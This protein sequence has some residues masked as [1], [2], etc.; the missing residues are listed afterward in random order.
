MTTKPTVM[1]YI[2]IGNKAICSFVLIFT[3]ILIFSCKPSDKENKH[4]EKIPGTD[5]SFHTLKKTVPEKSF[6]IDADYHNWGGSMIKSE[7][8]KYHLFYSRWPKA[9]GHIAWV[10][11]SEIAHAVADDPL[12]PYNFKDIALPHR[13]KEYWDG[14]MTHNPTIHKLGD[15]YYLYYIGTYGDGKLHYTA[16]NEKGE[17]I[18]KINYS[19]RNNQRIGVAIADHPEG[20]WKRFDEPLIDVSDDSTASDNLI[21]V[22]PSVARRPDGKYLLVYKAATKDYTKES[23]AGPVIHRVAISDSPDGPFIK[24]PGI[25]FDAGD[26]FFPAEDPYIWYQNDRFFAIVKDMHGAFTD[27]GRALVLFESKEGLNWTL[28]DKPL[29]SKLQ[30]E[31]AD[32]SIKKF[33]RLERPQLY[34]ENGKPAILFVA[35][36]DGKQ[37]YN[38]HIPLETDYSN[39]N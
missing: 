22:N 18:K 13:G 23:L 19:H 38:I 5:F 10:V 3:V 24:Q 33:Q 15:K 2:F 9:S 39:I 8:G 25:I 4:Q 26:S 35:V 16:K 36:R 32:G 34:F 30:I 1:N 28:A 27:K 21:V 17:T 6:L 31:K 14:M 20:P 11:Q 12:G 29:V 7:D 37:S